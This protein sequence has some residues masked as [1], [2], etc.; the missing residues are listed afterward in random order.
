ME[1]KQNAV[2]SD[3]ISKRSSNILV[4]WQVNSFN[5]I[6]IFHNIYAVLFLLEKMADL[7]EQKTLVL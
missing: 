2:L 3:W 5:I 6:Y 4:G 1:T 7:E